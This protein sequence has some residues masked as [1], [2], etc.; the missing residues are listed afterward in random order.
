[1]F[2]GATCFVV[3]PIVKGGGAHFGST[4]YMGYVAFVLDIVVAVAANMQ[5]NKAAAGA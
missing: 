1:M 5:K 2:V 3:D 4:L